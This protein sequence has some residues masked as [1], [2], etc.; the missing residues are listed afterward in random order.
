[1]ETKKSRKACR[2]S[3]AVIYEYFLSKPVMSAKM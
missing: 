2:I 3:V 1:L